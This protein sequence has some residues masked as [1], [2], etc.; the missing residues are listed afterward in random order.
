MNKFEEKLKEYRERFNDNF[1]IMTCMCMTEEEVIEEIQKCL[2]R[3]E[4]YE[5]ETDGDKTYQKLIRMK[6]KRFLQQSHIS[7]LRELKG[8]FFIAKEV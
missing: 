6:N 2:D 1:P 7:L 3:N 5:V 8:S 4:I